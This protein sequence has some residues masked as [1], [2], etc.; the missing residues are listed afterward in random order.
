MSADPSRLLKERNAVLSEL[1]GFVNVK[2]LVNPGPASKRGKTVTCAFSGGWNPALTAFRF[3][4]TDVCSVPA[5]S[6]IAP[7]RR[8]PLVIPAGFSATRRRPGDACD[9][10][11]VWSD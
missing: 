6:V 10:V 7:V 1:Y 2:E 3:T 4:A 8:P 11:S 9:T 5:V